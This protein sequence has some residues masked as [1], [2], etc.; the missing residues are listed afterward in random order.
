MEITKLPELQVRNVEDAPITKGKKSVYPPKF[1][2]TDWAKI[3]IRFLDERA[4]FITA[5]KKQTQSDYEAL[6]FKDEKRD[7]PNAAWVFL[8]SLARNNGETGE[9]PTPISDKIKQRKLQVA[10]RLKAIFKTDTDPFYDPTETRTYR[11]KIALIPP[12][13]NETRQDALGV[14]EYLKDTMTEKYEDER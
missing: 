8:L 11:I 13:T 14:D 10:D 2:R 7:K 5:D 4:V 9:L 3:T 6:G 1:S 12:P